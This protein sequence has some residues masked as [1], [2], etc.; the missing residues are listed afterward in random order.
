MPIDLRRILSLSALILAALACRTL[1]PGESPKTGDPTW[2]SEPD[3]SLSSPMAATSTRIPR[4]AP[5]PITCVEDACLN[6]CIERIH[7]VVNTGEFDPIGG[8]YAGTGANLNL[9]I[10]NVQDGSLGEPT[11]LYVPQEFKPFQADVES[12][13]L[14]WR[15]A[16][17]FL[18]PKLLKWIREYDIFTD[19]PDNG[20][21]W[22]NAMDEARTD[23]ELGI[24][25]ADAQDPV[26]L[27]YV[28]V[29]EY[30]HLITLNSDQ[31]PFNDY[32]YYGWSQN[33]A[34]CE[35]FLVP[36]GCTKPDSYMNLFYQ[37]F[38]VD[39]L[40]EWLES[41]E[42]VHVDTE[43]ELRDLVDHFYNRHEQEFIRPY[44]ATNMYED[45]ADSF[46]YFVLE[47]K[48]EG[49]A[50]FEKKILFFYDFPE[51]VAAREQMI[52]NICSYMPQD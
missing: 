15:Y 17:A 30:G 7:A 13:Q 21:A 46:M 5:Q 34:T 47:L 29:H 35:Q 31:I 19:G 32:Y 51:L 41:V 37:A 11:F 52:E 3:P 49:E 9:V 33:P 23:W 20:L 40:E 50:V 14:V 25:I 28:L 24:D 4:P 43:E 38:W 1:L 39:L 27:T 36:D 45:M 6:A 12:Q 26:Q 10:Y 2:E 44:A 8:S 18:P 22:V 48:P 16:A 42:K